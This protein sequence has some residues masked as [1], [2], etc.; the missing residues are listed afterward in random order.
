MID[1]VEASLIAAGVPTRHVHAERFGVPG[2]AP[3]RQIDIA[4]AGNPVSVNVMLDGK[5]Y[6]LKLPRAGRSI[7]DAALASGLDL[8]FSCKSGVCCTC[9]AKLLE[10]RVT[11]EKNYT[12]E[13]WEIAQ[14]YILTCQA[15]P[16]SNTV[17]VS[18][19]DR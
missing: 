10:G 18:F 3:P 2:T 19:D 4:D 11:M 7:L 16:A 12:L 15:H 5:H 1:T 17:V 14:G 8:P 9:R 6:G 13:Q